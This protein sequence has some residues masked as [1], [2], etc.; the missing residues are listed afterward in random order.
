VSLAE[1][2]RSGLSKYATFSGRARRSEYWWFTLFAVLA[3]LV[4]V[5]LD[6]AIPLSDEFN[7]FAPLVLL[8]LF[9]PQLSVLVRR[10][11]DTGRS[12]WWYFIAFIPLIGGI[13]LLVLLLNG[14]DKVDNRY[15][16]SPKYGSS[17]PG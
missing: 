2:V 6:V 4:G 1:A 8:G 12:G 3:V 9:L 5:A 17:L 15:G 7:V 13:W 11:H 14:G 16:S 10:L